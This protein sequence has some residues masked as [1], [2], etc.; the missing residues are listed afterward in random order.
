[1]RFIY[2]GEESI[3]IGGYPAWNISSYPDEKTVYHKIFAFLLWWLE[4]GES[5]VIVWNQYN[6]YI[7][8]FVEPGTYIVMDIPGW[9]LST[10]FE[11]IA[12]TTGDVNH[13]GIVNILDAGKISAHWY[14]GPPVGPLGYNPAADLNNDASV[15]ILD[16]S[17]VSANWGK[18][19]P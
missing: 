18:T 5:D 19:L 6:E 2:I 11:I 7:E 14:S 1:M 16:A 15:N 3:D 13:D 9:G 4:P 17:M 10:Y 8:S 12:A